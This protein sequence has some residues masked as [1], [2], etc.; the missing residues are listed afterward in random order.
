MVHQ[1]RQEATEEEARVQP[2]VGVASHSLLQFRQ[3]AQTMQWVDDRNAWVVL[4]FDRG[5]PVGYIKVNGWPLFGV[6]EHD[7]ASVVGAYVRPQYR[8]SRAFLALYRRAAQEARDRGAT[9]FQVEVAHG[10]EIMEKWVS[11][12][13]VPLS[14]TWEL[15]L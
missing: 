13:G 3:F 9:R 14:R 15:P 6:N 8:D 5:S 4:C 1:L 11:R 10:N 2:A 12:R 7:T